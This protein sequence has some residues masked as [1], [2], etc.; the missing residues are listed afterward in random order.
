MNRKLD[1]EYGME[2]IFPG[3]DDVLSTMG[4]RELKID[5]GR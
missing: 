3:R 5:D 1:M 2:N 4:V